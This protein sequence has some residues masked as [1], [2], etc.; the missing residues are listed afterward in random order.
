MS[1]FACQAPYSNRQSYSIPNWANPY[2]AAVKPHYFA[3]P[4]GRVGSITQTVAGS[5]GNCPTFCN[6][7]N[8]GGYDWICP[9]SS[10]CY[11]QTSP[12]VGWNPQQ[13]CNNIQ[14]LRYPN[15]TSGCS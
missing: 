4:A 11:S 8:C 14:G 2:N 3:D 12:V 7:S 5:F 13:I 6:S 9:M 10:P 1:Y 15:C